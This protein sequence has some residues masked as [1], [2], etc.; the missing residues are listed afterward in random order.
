[1]SKRTLTLLALIFV[2]LLA[3]CK[4]RSTDKV[5]GNTDANET[6]NAADS[7]AA[8]GTSDAKETVTDTEANTDSEGKSDTTGAADTTEAADT[9]VTPD[10]SE[11]IGAK[12]TINVTEHGVSAGNLSAASE[13]TKKLNK[14]IND[15]A[16][17]T[18]L[19]FP[20]GVYYLDGSIVLQG[21]KNITL[22]GDSARL[23]NTSYNPADGA[24]STKYTKSNII[25]LS[26]CENITI[27]G[28]SA[29]YLFHTSADGVIKS[30]ENGK[31]YVT[32]FDEFVSGDKKPLSGGEYVFAANYF[33]SYG[34]VQSDEA[35]FG[36][37]LEAAGSKLF[38]IEGTLGKVGQQIT[39]RFSSGTYAAPMVYISC[40]NGLTVKNFSVNSCPS[41]VFY[42]P[43]GSEDFSFENVTIAP[44]DGSRAF[45][46][47]NED[48]IHIKGLRGT[49]TIKNCSFVG[50]GDD[51][52]NVHSRIAPV[53]KT[54]GNSVTS[55]DAFYNT[56]LSDDWGKSGDTVLF[57]DKNYKE[58]GTATLKSIKGGKLTFDSL[59]SGVDNSCF[60][61]NLAFS[62]ETTV[63]G[64]KVERGRARGFLLQ[65]KKATV[66]NC[67]FKNLRLPAILVSPDF[68][69]WYEGGFADDVLIENCVFEKCAL[70]EMLKSAGVVM[71]TECHDFKTLVP[72]GVQPH[73]SV[74]LINNTFTD[75]PSYALYAHAVQKVVF[76]GSTVTSCGGKTSLIGCGK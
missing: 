62:P 28:F 10:T 61:Q 58:L 36:A 46:G 51:A 60:M 54:D 9:A 35:Y 47:T 5:T 74:R 12:T 38:C 20:K 40:V 50:I 52:L 70:H 53:N 42:A 23:I 18:V 16:E 49:L 21:K 19:S 27:D 64:C 29:D 1:M 75:C 34:T 66:K 69:S 43:S 33:D 67:S 45:L 7:T 31:T 3:G 13:N 41:A 22:K 30:H 15:A 63:S 11:P 71:V 55:L 6:E 17:N 39:L 76:D 37:K 25:G 32:V 14:L 26:G 8:P 48:C 24:D 44:A 73:K 4:E 72:D 59:P 65:T 68:D 57:Y 2:L 56:S